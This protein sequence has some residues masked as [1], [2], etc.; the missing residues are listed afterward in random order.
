[1]NFG[2][3]YPAHQVDRTALYKA[4]LLAELDNMEGRDSERERFLCEL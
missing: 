2:E 3:L 1:M 4:L